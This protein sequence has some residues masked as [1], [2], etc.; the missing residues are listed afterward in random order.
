MPVT[1]YFKDLDKDKVYYENEI[2]FQGFMINPLLNSANLFLEGDLQFALDIV[3][4]NKETFQAKLKEIA[5][6]ESQS[7]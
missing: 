2:K 7:Q 3:Q 4:K 6:K 5:D 1:P